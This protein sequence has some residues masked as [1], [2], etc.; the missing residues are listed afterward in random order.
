M[1]TPRLGGR[2]SE[3]RGAVAVI[4]TLCMLSLLVT[5]AMVLDFGL[6]R[7]NR[8]INKTAA[9]S[10]VAAGLQAANSVTG[11]ISNG[12][13][14]CT[15]YQFLKASRP[16]LSG[17]P[18]DSCAVVNPAQTCVPGNSGTDMSY[19]GTTTSGTTRYEVWIKSPYTMADT[20]MGGAFPE[21][22]STSTL[23]S[24]K[25]DPAQSGCD[26]VG[27]VIKQWT[28]PGLGKLVHNDDLVTRVRSVARVKVNTDDLPPALLLIEPHKCGVLSVGSAGSA[29]RIKVYGSLTTP[30][31][32]HVDSDAADSSC[33]SGS[34]QQLIQ[35]KQADAIVAYGSTTGAPGSI[36]TVATALGKPTNVVADNPLNVYGTTALNEAVT[37]V[38]S[39]VV[40]RTPVTR[41]PVDKR[42]LPGVKAATMAAYAKWSMSHS[43]PPGFT[44]YGC[45]TAA[46]M[47]AMSLLTASSSVYIDCPGNSGI[48]LSGTIG[49]GTV[50]FHG[51]IK[52]GN[53]KL[54]NARS[55]YVDNTD[56]SGARIST[57]AISLTQAGAGFCV[58]ALL[59]DTLGLGT[60]SNLPTGSV[61]ANATLMIR[62][63]S[64]DTNGGLLRMCNTR[65]ILQGG[66]LG[67][68]TT[69]NPGGCLPSTN[70]TPP[71]ATPC[72]DASTTAGNGIVALGGATDW[73]A[74]NAYTSLPAAGYLNETQ[75][76][77]LWDQGEDLA[78][79]TETYG[80][81]AT[82]KMTGGTNLHVN[83]VFMTPN[84]GPFTLGGGGNIDLTNSQ[85]I[86]TSFAVAGGAV[87]TMK[88]DPQ[89][90]VGLPSL[91]DFQLVR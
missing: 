11:D 31:T 25:G 69:G 46:N 3:Q 33:G 59:C 91:Q 62:R 50:Y 27:V 45:P 40:G 56:D 86:A 24:D 67:N 16:A 47:T 18:V 61:T 48:T 74:P 29:S 81:G 73:T 17:L 22:T 54:P 76:H 30:A 5:G 78:L 58:R 51:W 87:L 36:S 79:W 66:G 82:Y 63:G 9:D 89:N 35:G 10:A 68:G 72:T 34:G 6:V 42:Y 1:L 13:A 77:V 39:P 23:S 41:R 2:R 88:V 90:A 70:G 15:A 28:K 20:S 75:K 7:Y 55:V 4:V 60:C 65:A 53:L 80:S 14:V 8:Q 84:A 85:F 44:R 71:T 32:I 26:Q 83:G 52:N 21:E 49:A 64:I 12:T 43:A 37:G 19:H 38:V 57:Q